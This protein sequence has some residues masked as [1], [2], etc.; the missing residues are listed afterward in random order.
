[1][2]DILDSVA[3]EPPNVGA[4]QV[5]LAVK[6]QYGLQGEYTPLVSERDQNFKLQSDN[7]QCYVVKIA[8]LAEEPLVTDFQI[9][10]LSHLETEDIA[11]VPRIVRTRRGADRGTVETGVADSASLRLVTWVEGTLL[12]DSQ[13]TP[14]V[15]RRF[16]RYLARLDKALVG[17]T[18]P[19][20]AQLLLWDTQRASELRQLLRYVD[21][22][23]VRKMI[24]LAL[25]DFEGCTQ[26]AIRCLPS[27]VIHNDAN[28][29]NVLVDEE[30]DIAGIIDFGDMLAAPRAI[31]VSTAA[32]YLRNTDGDPLNLVVP[33]VSGYHDIFPLKR[34]EIECLYDLIRARL[35][36]T[37]TILY[38]R[39]SA[40]KPGDPY[41]EKSL[42]GER[43]AYDFLLALTNKGQ[44]VVSER[45]IA[46]VGMY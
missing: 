1:M 16:G 5:S 23:E 46:A 21:S 19:G 34:A 22:I 26:D 35:A 18:H 27:Q 28:S 37:L 32:A 41:R 11:G 10:A 24:E 31:E 3:A 13:Q 42:A 43:A 20:D 45:L 33:F 38:W 29:D 12:S 8:S 30:G 7:G 15:A 17:F 4:A 44:R 9:A 14:D 40:R 2:Q 39:L 36:M 25:D 6:E